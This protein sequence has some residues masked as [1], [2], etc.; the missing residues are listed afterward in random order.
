MKYIYY[1]L[2][3]LLS[4]NSIAQQLGN[5]S[6]Y[7]IER[8]S[9]TVF[10]NVSAT[11][12]YGSSIF[13]NQMLDKF[14]YGGFV[15]DD[16][17]NNALKKAKR[18]N[19]LGGELSAKI[20]Y[21]NTQNLLFKDWG[22]YV[23]LSYN[24]NVG[25]QFTKDAYQLVFYGNKSLENKEAKLSPSAFYLRDVNQFSFGLNKNN[26]FKI[27]LTIS[28]F[29][30]NSGAEIT[31][32][33]FFTDTNGSSLSVDVQGEYFAVDTNSSVRFL[34]N[35]ALGVGVDF[36]TSFSL[37]ENK[38][39]QKIVLGV[40][41]VGVLVQKNTYQISVN[42]TYKYNGIE[43]NSLKNIGEGL[44]TANSLQD[45]LGIET[46]IENRTSLL[47]FEIYFFQLPS[48]KKRIELIY[49]FRFKYESAYKA[50]LY[51]GG[52]VKLNEKYSAATFISHGGYANFQWG[53]SA[54]THFSK[55]YLGVNTNN[56]LGFISKKAYGKSI[57]INLTYLL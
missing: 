7:S 36:E 5:N 50:F 17:K 57:G 16:L 44:L 11:G 29:N 54:Q 4:L 32:G 37:K 22:Y 23:G 31:E 25:T 33:T 27:G 45:S 52:N 13:N 8:D 41:N 53:L 6:Q 10:L 34:T 14:I 21:S 30:N 56:I 24:Y 40:K 55:V 43:I 46:K 48:Y 9:S 28:S 47:P 20:Y 42:T 35:N 3:L 19:Y 1:I 51:A 38:E 18:L 12:Y 2:P 39:G 15:D 49:G 26:Q